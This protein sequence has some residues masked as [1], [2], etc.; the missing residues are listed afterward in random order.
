MDDFGLSILNNYILT[1]KCLEF[2][3]NTITYKYKKLNTELEDRLTFIN[4]S[5][6]ET[7]S[8]EDDKIIDRLMT[9][10]KD[11]FSKKIQFSHLYTV[12]R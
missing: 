7:L 2:L 1:E 6:V 10:N 3:N 5:T 11:Y 8:L 4:N 12:Y 9:F